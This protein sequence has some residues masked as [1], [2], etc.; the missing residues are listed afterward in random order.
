MLVVEVCGNG[1]LIRPT[2]H[3]FNEWKD[4]K[5]TVDVN[6]PVN[7]HYLCIVR[8]LVPF[9]CLPRLRAVG[10]VSLNHDV[11]EMFADRV[12]PDLPDRPFPSLS[13]KHTPH[14][15]QGYWVVNDSTARSW[16]APLLPEEQTVNRY[17]SGVMTL[18]TPAPCRVLQCVIVS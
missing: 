16:R 4:T 14:M 6:R 9:V 12:L 13:S 5:P 1:L 11:V 3:S 8:M 18:K 15:K 7:E 2:K 10:H 17:T